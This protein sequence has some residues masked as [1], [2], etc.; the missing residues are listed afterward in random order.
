MLGL[1]DQLTTADSREADAAIRAWAA[2]ADPEL[3]ELLALVRLA[4]ALRD[5]LSSFTV[6]EAP[7][8][9]ITWREYEHVLWT[10]GEGFRQ[11]LKRRPPLRR[12]PVLF[13]AIAALCTETANRNGRES[14]TMLLGQYGGPSQAPTLVGLLDDPEVD[15]HAL[16]ALR[17]LKAPGGREAALRLLAQGNTWK[18]NEAKK[19]LRRL[20]PDEVAT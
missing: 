6:V 20:Y 10:L 2:T 9:H 7:S 3:D 13:R 5:R 14:F 17:T 4:P 11:V 16:F 12:H 1:V 18:R 15:G 19:Y 8:G